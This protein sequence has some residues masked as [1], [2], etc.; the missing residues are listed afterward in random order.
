MMARPKPKGGAAKRLL[1]Q[2]TRPPPPLPLHH[3]ACALAEPWALACDHCQH[4]VFAE[5]VG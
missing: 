4:C 5:G 1:L 2:T 3:G